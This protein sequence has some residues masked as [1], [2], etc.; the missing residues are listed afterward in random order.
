MEPDVGPLQ[1]EACFDE[2]TDPEVDVSFSEEVR[3]LIFEPETNGCLLCH[4]PDA[5]TPIG[6]EVTGLDLSNFTGILRGGSNSDG[7]AVIPGRPC[8]SI[9]YQKASAGPPFGARMP[10]GGP[11]YLSEEQ[12]QLLHDWISEGAKDN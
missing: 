2:D 1:Q 11:P 5:P 7:T 3:R 12:L 8:Q 10:L 6:Y 4:A 9:L